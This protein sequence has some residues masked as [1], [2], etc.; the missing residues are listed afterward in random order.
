MAS[1]LRA[2]LYYPF[3]W[4]WYGANLC[5]TFTWKEDRTDIGWYRSP[6]CLDSSS[7]CCVFWFPQEDERNRLSLLEFLLYIFFAF[8][9]YQGEAL[10]L[11]METKGQRRWGWGDGGVNGCQG[12]K[13]RRREWNWLCCLSWIT[14]CVVVNGGVPKAVLE[15]HCTWAHKLKGYHI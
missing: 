3:L 10:S 13:G 11:H 9:K 4:L 2:G 1:I 6:S 12:R 7:A 8:L 15:V 5:F 14:E